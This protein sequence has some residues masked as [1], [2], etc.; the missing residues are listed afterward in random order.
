ML[1]RKE[2]LKG[3]LAL[4]VRE[5]PTPVHE[6]Q[7][8]KRSFQGDYDCSSFKTHPSLGPVAQVFWGR[9][10]ESEKTSRAI[11]CDLKWSALPHPGKKALY[12]SDSG[13]V[14]VYQSIN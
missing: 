14:F 5:L 10:A 3:C 1:F 7:I 2:T 13:L 9:M 8:N 6:V 12:V 11:L 4:S